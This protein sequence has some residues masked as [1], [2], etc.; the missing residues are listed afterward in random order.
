MQ[1]IA[2]ARRILKNQG[3]TGIIYEVLFKLHVR[4]GD[5]WLTDKLIRT[6]DPYSYDVRETLRCPHCHSHFEKI[7]EGYLC[8]QC[9]DVYV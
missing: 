6:H 4:A 1:K 8:H 2:T 3:F 9:Q 5:R 7:T